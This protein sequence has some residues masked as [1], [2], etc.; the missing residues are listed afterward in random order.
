MVCLGCFISTSLSTFL[1]LKVLS[2]P[3]KLLLPLYPLFHSISTDRNL[4]CI[5]NSSPFLMPDIQSP[6]LTIFT[7][8]HFLTFYSFPF[9]SISIYHCPRSGQYYKRSQSFFK[10]AFSTAT[11]LDL[12]CEPRGQPGGTPCTLR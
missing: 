5:L 7:P 11:K 3:I 6:R 4:G 9:I 12:K 10:S 2:S 8:K 1:K